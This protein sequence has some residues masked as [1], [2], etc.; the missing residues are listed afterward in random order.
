[1]PWRDYLHARLGTALTNG[2]YDDH[3]NF[4]GLRDAVMHGRILFPTY[5]AFKE[6]RATIRR[7]E[8]LIDLLDSYV[9]LRSFAE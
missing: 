8:G 9:T 6:G 2:A 7:M 5:N 3:F 4:T 1:M